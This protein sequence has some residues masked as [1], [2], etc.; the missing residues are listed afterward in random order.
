GPGVFKVDWA[1]DGP[2]P[3]RAEECAKSATVHVGGTIEEIASHEADIWKGRNGGKPFVLVA[4]QT[5]FDATRAPAGK[6]TGWAYCHVP[7]GA[8][9]DMAD[10][11]EAQVE[12]FAPGFRDR[13]LARHVSGP[14]VLEASNRN[15]AGGDFNGGVMDLKQIFA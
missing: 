4:Q 10:R 6:H 9:V 7:H 3:W 11:V 12:R 5:L 15:Y 13:I 1:L 14:R 2:I 8:D